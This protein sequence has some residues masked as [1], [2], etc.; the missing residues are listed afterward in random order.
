MS[1]LLSILQSYTD[2]EE[3]QKR[4]RIF[5]ANLK[6]IE[7]RNILESRNHGTA[8]HGVTKFA[9]L[10]QEEF[11]ARFLGGRE[12]GFKEDTQSHAGYK[13]FNL[14]TSS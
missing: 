4:F 5:K 8:V 2:K 6:M 10:S 9:D 3:Y 13:V 1:Y 11:E 12:T 14:T 7:Q